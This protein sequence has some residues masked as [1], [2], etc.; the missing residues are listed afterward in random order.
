M[1]TTKRDIMKKIKNRERAENKYRRE[2]AKHIPDLWKYAKT[3]EADEDKAYKL[4]SNTI[5]RAVMFQSENKAEANYETLSR[6]MYMQF[7]E[8]FGRNETEP[9]PYVFARPIRANLMQTTLG[10][11]GK[12][13]SVH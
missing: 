5:S 4:L 6:L 1:T 3:I 12:V 2:L 9:K 10:Q 7:L 11:R 8:N 13:V